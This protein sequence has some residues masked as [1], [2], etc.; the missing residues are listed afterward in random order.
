MT[1]P[2]F[3]IA[4]TARSATTSLYYYLKQHPEIGFP[5]KKEPKYF[6]SL[7]LDFPHNGP[8][9]HTVDR[10]M[11]RDFDSYRQLFDGLESFKRIGD[12]SS[13]YLYYHRHSAAGI[14]RVLG[15]VPIILCLRN[16][17]E[18]AF[19]AYNNL[20]RD[21]RETLTLKD[22]LDSEEQRLHDN[23]DWMWA[24]K[25]GGL[26]AAQVETFM[27]TFSQVKV[28]LYEWLRQDA[29]AVVR[30]LL[31]FLGVDETLS[32]NTSVRYSHSGRAKNRLVAYLSNRNNP[33]A[34]ALRRTAL[35]L[36]PRSLLE[37]VASRSLEKEEMDESL[38]NELRS[39]FRAD[40]EQL[41]S[42]LGIDLEAWK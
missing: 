40:T 5:E 26:Y 25:A 31:A 10:L 4:G 23:W 29:D 34:Y 32:V 20:L 36:L 9:D 2:N 17:V 24:Y 41:E 3:V 21:Q 18:R 6:S 37:R 30:E 22:A 33:L 1:L 8:G 39:Y 7:G 11:V 42:L 38:R 35:M 14:R 15:D 19:S 16:P 27:K 13:D 12:A 28:V